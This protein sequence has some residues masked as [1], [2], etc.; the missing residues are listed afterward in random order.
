MYNFIDSLADLAF[1]NKELSSKPYIGIDTEFRR[2]NKHNMRLA[3]LQIND[4]EDIYIIDAI[5]INNPL[6]HAGFLFSPSV[7]KILHS[8][9][10]DIEAIYSWTNSKIV[11]IFDTQLAH[12]FLSDEYSISYQGLVEKNLGIFLEKTETRS[13]WFRRPLTE[14]QLKYASLDVEYLIYLYLMQSENLSS[15]GKLEWHN[16]DV[17][18]LIDSALSL[19]EMES[20]PK[21]LSKTAENN[22]LYKLN[23][24]VEEIS[25]KHQISKT[26]FFSKRSQ[27]ELIRSVKNNG[28]N[29]ACNRMSS[30]RR[31][32]ILDSLLE[33]FE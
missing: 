25:K 9:K 6:E 23:L 29:Q 15:N 24:V 5:K 1:L 8:C 20:E 28:I 32:L 33:I 31:D 14:N 13:N 30:W 18:R 27:I 3:L 10:E 16:Q 17:K 21:L 11:N 12:A 2:T 22:F 7:K 26:L 19:T 4:G